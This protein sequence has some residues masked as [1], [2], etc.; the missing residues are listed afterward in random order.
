LFH[1]TPAE[2]RLE[3]GGTAPAGFATIDDVRK[4][5]ASGKIPGGQAGPW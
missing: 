1:W 3:W 2:T 4:A 5:A